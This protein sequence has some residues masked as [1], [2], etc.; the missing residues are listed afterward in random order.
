[1]MATD[2]ACLP[3]GDHSYT[4]MTVDYLTALRKHTELVLRHKLTAGFFDSTPIE[5]IITVPAMWSEATEAKTRACAE[6]AGMGKASKLQIISEPEAA[7]TYALHRMASQDISIGDTFVLV[8]AGGGTV[9]L[10]SYTVTQLQPSF[11]VVEAGPGTGGFCG[12]TFL[13]RRF[14]DFLRKRFKNDPAWGDDELEEVLLPSLFL[15]I[16]D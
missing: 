13:N 11:Q 12:S 8:D 3:L 14:Q 7:A 9:D 15:G 1:M 10:I 2:A 5:Y 4:Q 6:Q 16:Q